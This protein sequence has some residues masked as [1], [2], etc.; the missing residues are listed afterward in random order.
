VFSMC[1]MC[2]CGVCM[3]VCGVVFARVWFD[4]CCMYVFLYGGM[5]LCV[6]VVCGISRIFIN[7]VTD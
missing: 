7:T 6:C 3:Y 5:C 1:G 2:V 4:M